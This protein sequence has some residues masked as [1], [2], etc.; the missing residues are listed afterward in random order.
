MV[1]FHRSLIPSDIIKNEEMNTMPTMFV[2][3]I[4]INR[5]LVNSMLFK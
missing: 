5:V 3:A 4:K 2:Y 1:H